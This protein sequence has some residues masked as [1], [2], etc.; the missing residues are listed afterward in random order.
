MDAFGA[1]ILL[2]FSQNMLLFSLSKSKELQ[3]K[4]VLPIAI[5]VLVMATGCVSTPG[6]LGHTV[7]ISNSNITVPDEIKELVTITLNGPARD[8]SAAYAN[9]GGLDVSINN[10]SS[11]I[12]KILWS[13]SSFLSP[14]GGSHTI[15]LTGMR[16]SDAGRNPPDSIIPPNS[17]SRS[18][19][20]YAENV[21]VGSMTFIKPI[22]TSSTTLLICIEVKNKEYYV[23]I[24]VSFA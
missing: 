15:L 6:G 9:P 21:L 3:M 13:K 16:Y 8:K 24:Q 12:I 11:A 1:K 17:F 4:R 18:Q 20:F 14:D 2:I 7:G 23:S 5:L 10:N 19:A 22:P